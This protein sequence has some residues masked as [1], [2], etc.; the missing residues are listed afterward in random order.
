MKKLIF[1]IVIVIL[2]AFAFGCDGMCTHDYKVIDTKASTCNQLG[3]TLSECT[4][5][6]NIKKEDETE[7]ASHSYNK[8]YACS[9]C[10]TATDCSLE[11][12]AEEY[13]ANM[14]ELGQLYAGT[15]TGEFEV[16]I[17]NAEDTYLNIQNYI[18]NP[19]IDP[20]KIT[21]GLFVK[22][23]VKNGGTDILFTIYYNFGLQ[24][25][26]ELSQDIAFSY[27]GSDEI[28]YLEVVEGNKTIAFE[29]SI[30]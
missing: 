27:I 3:Y 12:L 2:S 28:W 16:V 13:G 19:T 15:M 7:Y 22:F 24:F 17:L 4:K 5:C 10:G 25:S 30:T 6:K 9:V 1:L 18:T 23:D 14:L 29:Y 8:E 11:I 26:E 21:A 20:D